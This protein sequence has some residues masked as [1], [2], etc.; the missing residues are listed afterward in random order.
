M[1]P[2]IWHACHHTLVN[3][4]ITTKTPNIKVKLIIL[5]KFIRY[6]SEEMVDSATVYKYLVYLRL[7]YIS[8]EITQLNRAPRKF[9]FAPEI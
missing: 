5:F 4:F 9:A 3:N 1:A 7:G 2:I 6:N 8:S